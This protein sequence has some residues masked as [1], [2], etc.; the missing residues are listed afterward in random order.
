MASETAEIEIV[1]V[2]DATGLKDAFAEA[3]EAVDE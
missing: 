3:Y 2:G 1:F